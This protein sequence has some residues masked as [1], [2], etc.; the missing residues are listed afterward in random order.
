MITVPLIIPILWAE[1]KLLSAKKN[2]SSPSVAAFFT[3]G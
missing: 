1:N 3:P 2:K